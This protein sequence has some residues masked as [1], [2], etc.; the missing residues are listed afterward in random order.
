[1]SRGLIE[2]DSEL[3]YVDSVNTT[4]NTVTLYPWGRGQQGSTAAA[5]ADDAKVTISPRFPRHRVKTVINEVIRS[6]YPS[7][8]G[9]ATYTG[10]DAVST[11]LTYELPA[12]TR[13]IISVSWQLTG[14]SEAWYPLHRWRLDRN[15]DT[16]EFTSGVSLDILQP[17][18][19]GQ[20]IKVVYRKEPSELSAESDNFATVTGLQESA[21]DVVVWGALA[22]LLPALEFA[23]LHSDAVEQSDRQRLLQPGSASAAAR[24][25][26]QMHTLR[27]EQERLKLAQLYPPTSH[28]T[29]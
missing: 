9:V 8:F 22:H 27:L 29:R 12:A 25:A 19:P 13:S 20:T 21:R 11:R 6:L 4:T 17:M 1:V 10:L 18:T 16:S 28:L 5:H 15:A 26:L 3:L 24:Q 14:P 23:R 7:L 2:I